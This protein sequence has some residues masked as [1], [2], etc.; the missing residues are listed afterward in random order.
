MIICNIFQTTFVE[1]P[2]YTTPSY[3]ILKAKVNKK[4]EILKYF[5]SSNRQLG[6]FTTDKLDSA[7]LSF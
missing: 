4:P 2:V 6:H 7:H 5:S 1:H 3:N